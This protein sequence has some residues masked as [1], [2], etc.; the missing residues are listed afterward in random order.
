MNDYQK[1]AKL[2]NVAEITDDYKSNTDFE[3]GEWHTADDY[4]VHVMTQDPHNI[5]FEY[6]VFYYEPSFRTVIQR[7]EELD[8]DAVVY[9]ADFET[10]LPSYEVEDYIQQQELE[11]LEN[12][13]VE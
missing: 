12:L 10:Y 8:S 2:L 3:I 5:D 6:D 1:L 11:L 13:E 4:A 9:V 7:I